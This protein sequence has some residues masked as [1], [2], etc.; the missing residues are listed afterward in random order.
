M[1]HGWCWFTCTPARGRI[2]EYPVYMPTAIQQ[3]HMDA[4]HS[5]MPNNILR[6]PTNFNAGM[7]MLP[8]EFA[9]GTRT[10]AGVPAFEGLPRRA[11]AKAL[12]FPPPIE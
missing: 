3:G 2:A 12:F 9:D 8:R 4:T 6:V 7:V 10:Q 5:S 11:L 1:K